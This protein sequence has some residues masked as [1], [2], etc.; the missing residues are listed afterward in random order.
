MSEEVIHV[1]RTL[2][3]RQTKLVVAMLFASLVVAFGAVSTRGAE[4]ISDRAAVEDA[5][6][7]VEDETREER[8]VVVPEPGWSGWGDDWGGVW[9]H[10]GLRVRIWTDRGDGAV[11][12]TGDPLWVFFRVNRPCYVTIVDHTPDGRVNLLFPNRWSGS[13]YVH[14]GRTYRIPESRGYALRIAGPGGY[15]TLVA[16]AH[17]APWPSGASGPW[18]P[19]PM[20]DHRWTWPQGSRPRGR[21][22]VGGHRPGRVVVGSPGF[23]P[24]PPAWRDHPRSWATDS[25]GLYVE[26]GWYGEPYGE[27][28]GYGDR[29]GGR[30]LLDREFRMR[31]ASDDFRERVRHRGETAIVSIEAVESS[32]GDAT[33]I[34]GRLG[35]DDG[36]GSEIFMR[37]DVDGQNGRH[38]RPG[39]VVEE[40]AGSLRVRVEVEDV[41]IDRV[42]PHGRPV[43]EWIEFDVTIHG[44]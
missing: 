5:G 7:P 20:I 15:E 36:W 17:E 26:G 39:L 9:H 18:L 42:G 33:E 21:V 11:Y 27:W 19:P 4:V 12:R 35:W 40:R 14:P 22:V 25:V 38:P 13:N 16:C 2:S 32:H 10:G 1:T 28:Y 3:L 37:L 24:V 31:R 44:H 6:R 43:I 8:V 29:P 41:E 23:W 30:L 34:V